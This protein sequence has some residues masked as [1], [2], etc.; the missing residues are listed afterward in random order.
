MLFGDDFFDHFIEETDDT[1]LG[2]IS[3][4]DETRRLDQCFA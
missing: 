3:R 4:L 1:M 2:D